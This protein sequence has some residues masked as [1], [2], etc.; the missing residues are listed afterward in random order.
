MRFVAGTLPFLMVVP[1]ICFFS[2]MLML[3]WQFVKAV[4][5]IANSVEDIAITYRSSR[6]ANPSGVATSRQDEFDK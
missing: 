1:Y 2:L 6:P 5:S 3:A 4:T